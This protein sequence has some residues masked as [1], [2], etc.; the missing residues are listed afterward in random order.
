M[1]GVPLGLCDDNELKRQKRTLALAQLLGGGDPQACGLSGVSDPVTVSRV[2]GLS[3]P[4]IPQVRLHA[5]AWTFWFGQR[6]LG[7]LSPQPGIPGGS[8]FFPTS[9]DSVIV[10]TIQLFKSFIFSV[11]LALLV[12]ILRGLL[13]TSLPYWKK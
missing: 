12:Q 13:L 11:Y 4:S 8:G 5:P 3:D 10:L 7:K 1:A 9:E 6:P 2:S